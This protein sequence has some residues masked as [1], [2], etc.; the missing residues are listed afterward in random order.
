MGTILGKSTDNAGSGGPFIVQN[1]SEG[2]MNY[3]LDQNGDGTF[4]YNVLNATVLASETWHHFALTRIGTT[5]RAY[6]N[7]SFFSGVFFS[8]SLVDNAENLTIGFLNNLSGSINHFDGYL[9]DLRITKGVS[10]YNAGSYTIPTAP[11]PTS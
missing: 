3:L 8:G 9:A 5:I 10:R 4:D 6:R 11:Y 2:K 7:G 1:T